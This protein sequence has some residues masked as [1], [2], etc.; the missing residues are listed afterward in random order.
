MKGSHDLIQWGSEN[1]T[2][3]VFKW[4]KRGRMVNGPVFKCHLNTGQP[5]HLNTRYILQ[6]DT[7][8]LT[9]AILFSYV[10]VWYLNGRLG[11]STLQMLFVDFRREITEKGLK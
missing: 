3:L 9:D 8:P 1:Q 7:T 11:H 10:L 5:Q 4:S 2:S 6:L